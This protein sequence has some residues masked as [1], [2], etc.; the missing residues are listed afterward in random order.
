MSGGREE[1]ER[2]VGWR[3]GRA[4]PAERLLKHPCFSP[5][6]PRQPRQPRVMRAAAA[7]WQYPISPDGRLAELACTGSP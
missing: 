6:E 3:A 4:E 2:R 1:K 5:S 7:T